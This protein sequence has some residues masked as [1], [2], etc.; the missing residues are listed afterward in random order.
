MVG[1]LEVVGSLFCHGRYE[2]YSILRTLSLCGSVSLV[3]LSQ[4]YCRL[5]AIASL[6]PSGSPRLQSCGDLSLLSFLLLSLC[7]ISPNN[8][9]LLLLSCRDLESALSLGVR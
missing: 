6:V 7:S 5:A 9:I 3:E 1:Q 4:Q 2:L 8:P